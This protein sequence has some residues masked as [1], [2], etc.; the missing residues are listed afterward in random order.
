MILGG[1]EAVHNVTEFKGQ[2]QKASSPSPDPGLSSASPAFPKAAFQR[3]S[4]GR[5]RGLPLL[6]HPWPG[7]PL[8]MAVEQ[9]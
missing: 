7:L 3:V 2:F 8:Q 4:V 1:Q 5:Q 6:A 9:L